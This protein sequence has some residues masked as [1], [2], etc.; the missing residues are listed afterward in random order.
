MKHILLLAL[1]LI[2]GFAPAAS[3]IIANQNASLGFNYDEPNSYSIRYP[4]TIDWT[5]DG[6]RIL[7][8]PSS[9]SI[10][11]DIAD[12][13]HRGG[14]VTDN[15]MHIQGTYLRDAKSWGAVSEGIVYTVQGDGAGTGSSRIVEK[16]DVLNK[17]GVPLTVQVVGMGWT[18]Q[19]DIQPNQ[20]GMEIP[21]FTGVTG[22][23][24]AFIQG[25]TPSGETGFITDQPFAAS[26]VI[27][28]VSFSGFNTLNRE[29]IVPAGATLTVITELKVAP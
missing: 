28:V 23:T 22:T 2:P 7:V 19:P 25:N 29:V 15:Q 27:P 21:D 14:H 18:P 1:A 16:V 10:H 26:N 24:V 20:K 11:L 12:H 9:P 3:V 6:R 4:R 17:S 13:A 5:V 8:Y